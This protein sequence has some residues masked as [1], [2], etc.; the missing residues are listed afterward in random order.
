MR[1]IIVILFSVLL[2]SGK[3]NEHN[4]VYINTQADFDRYKN[5]EFEPGTQ[6]FFAVGKSFSGQFAPKGSGTKDLPI[7]LT[8][9]NPKS[10]KAYWDDIDNKPIINGH[11][12]VNSPI[13]LYNG[14]FWEINNLEVTNT[15]GTDEE[16]GDLRGIYIV[17][18]DAGI[19]ENITVRNCFIHDVN[20]K[21]EGKR[22]G[23]IHVHV[24]GKKVRTKFHNLLIENNYIKNVGGVGIGNSS[25]WG[26][27]NSNDYYP[28]T[29]FVIRGNRVEYTGRN[30]I[31]ARVGVNQIVEYNVLAYN[32]R[33]STGHSV[34]NFASINCIMQYNE[35]YGNTGDPGDIDH[36][37]FDADYNARGTIIQYNYSHDNNWFCG[38]MRRYNRDITIRYNISINERLGAYEYGFPQDDE[39]RGIWIYNNIHYFRAGL[40]ASIFASPGKVRTPSY[41]YFYN[42][43]F[44]FEDKG[45]WGVEPDETC[46][47]RN[48]L[49]YNV[50]PKGKGAIVADPLFVNPG[51]VDTDIDMHDPERLAGYMLK[52]NSPCIDAGIVI[53]DNGGKDF[54]GNPLGTESIDI[55][56]Y[57]QQKN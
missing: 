27:I 5:A 11:G 34:F 16:Q 47:F 8:A 57:E 10:N 12:E 17:A 24:K 54:W 45:T 42:N 21:V 13:Y 49:F 20:G 56:A 44:Y 9:Y 18:E 4:I 51:K 22:R 32:S 53:N 15:N 48:N 23:G 37:G 39:A 14:A 41:S 46:E 2:F 25:S 40:N 38:I 35:A 3:Q 7:K 31:I 55:G 19:I 30:G 26:K 29:D 43:I 50:A 6:I 36:G 52:D 1:T 28:W 33:Y